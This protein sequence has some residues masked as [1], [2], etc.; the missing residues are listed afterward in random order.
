MTAADAAM[1]ALRKEL[2]ELQVRVT[3]LGEENLVLRRICNENGIQYEER[4][5]ALGHKRYFAHLRAA[6]PI[7]RKVAASDVLGAIPIVRG[8]SGCAGSVFCTGLIARRF[9]VAFTQL[10]AQLPWRFG[11]QLRA[12]LEGPIVV[13]RNTVYSLA[14]LRSGRLASGSSDRTIK[15]WALA[16][17]AL[18]ATLE[19]HR[20]AVSS[21]AVLEGGRLASGSSDCMI[22]IWNL[23]TGAC[24]ATMEGHRR[25]VNCLAVLE[26]GRLASGSA[27]E[28]IK[29]WDSAL[30]DVLR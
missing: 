19:G 21:L 16:T 28:A 14:V 2:S 3:E 9:F 7:E 12:T 4:L 6:Y 1:Q 20:A 8:I 22:K 13:P 17:G 10:T 24:V 18:V 23:A 30:S 5:A 27:D 15:I 29:I 25:Q 26:G 11:G